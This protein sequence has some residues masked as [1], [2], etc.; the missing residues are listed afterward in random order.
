MLIC[1]S[2]VGGTE[3]LLPF[4][5][6]DACGFPSSVAGLALTAIPLGMAVV[7]PISGAVSDRIGSALPWGIGLAVYAVG[8]SFTGSLPTTAPLAW[9]VAGMLVMAVGMGLFQSPN[10]SLVMGS[11]GCEHLGFAGSV[12]SLVRYLGM[13]VGVTGGTALLYGHM[14]ALA[15]R[16]IASYAEGGVE[17]FSQGFA[18]TF[19]VFGAL[20]VVGVVLTVLAA[21]SRL[22]R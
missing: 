22:R 20:S 1:F 18:F 9:I 15:G 19:Y 11:V 7:G 21:R 5:L 14:S 6:Q 3:Y 8:I 13:S 10:N 4:F 2:A 12:V 16:P 17:L